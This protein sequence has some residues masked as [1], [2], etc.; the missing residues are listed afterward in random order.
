MILSEAR[1]REKP[2]VF[3]A[4]TGLQLAE[5]DALAQEL[6]PAVAAA[7]AAEAE[8]RRRGQRRQRAAGGGHPFALSFRTQLLLVVIWL[9]VYPTS[10][11]LGFLFGI[12][13]PTVLRTIG[14]VLPIL[15]QAGRDTMRLPGHGERGR[16]SRRS[17]NDLLVAIPDLTVIVDSF[18]QRVQRPRDPDEADRYYSGKQK[19]HTLKSQIAIDGSTGKVVDVSASVCG[20]TAD[21]TLL[22]ASGLLDRVAPDV[23]VLGDLAYVG[24]APLHPAGL[25]FTPRRKPREQPRPP[26]DVV[27]NTAFAAERITVEH[28][29]GRL[30]HY[31][32]L[33][34]QDRH[35]RQAHDARVRAVAGLVNRQLEHRFG[36]LICA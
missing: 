29:I 21:L 22:K 14:R 36:A 18:E 23:G 31:Q 17:L 1:L 8:R 3:R 2:G 16:R 7:A 12:S 10:P 27:Y 28:T 30:R 13:H 34:Q 35:H 11:V 5:F 26:E 33:T 6:E 25:G 19:Q 32:A 24:M 15:E 4:M 9:R 20:P